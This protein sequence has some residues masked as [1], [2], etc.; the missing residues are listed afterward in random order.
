MKS[1]CVV[2][3][4]D[5]ARFEVPLAYLGTS[6]FSELLTMSQEEFGFAGGGDG[7]IML[8]YNAA[9]MEYAICLLQR[10]AS[11]EVMKTFTSSIARPCSFEGS[12]VGV[13]LNQHV[14]VC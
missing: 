5:R 8:P 12:V 4:T 6:I 11:T 7:R 14:A 2:Y 13:V 10:D 9:V 1:H 3:T